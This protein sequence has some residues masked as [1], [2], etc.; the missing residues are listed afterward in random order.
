MR[1]TAVS[2]AHTPVRDALGR[3]LGDPTVE[4]VYWLPERG[5]WVHTDGTRAAVPEAAPGRS[6]TTVDFGDGRRAAIVHDAAHDQEAAFLE[7]ALAEALP[8]LRVEGLETSL[9]AQYLF[10]EKI[11]DTAPSLLINLDL[12]G[13]IL[14]QNRSAVQ[15]AG[16]TEEDELRGLSFVDVFTDGSDR[17]GDV[18]RFLSVDASGATTDLETVFS[19]RRGETRAIAWRAAP[20]DDDYGNVISIVV[21]GTDVSERKARE[22]ELA[23][24]R[25]ATATV[26]QTIPSV[27]VVLGSDLRIV[28]RDVNNPRAGVNDAFRAALGWRD[29]D[30]VSKDFLELIAV[31][32][33][34]RAARVLG[35]AAE[36][37]V[38]ERV[39]S[40]WLGVDGREP[41]FEWN[42][43]PMVDTTGRNEGLILISGI[44]VTD[45]RRYLAEIRASRA[46]IVESA[47]EARRRIERDLHDGAQQR[48]VSLSLSLRLARAKLAG[49]PDEV[50]A[51]LE[52]AISE[53]GD[54]LTE[55]R[56][57]ARGIHPVVLTE[58]GLAAA[59]ETLVARAQIEVRS[60]IAVPRLDPAVEAAVYFVIAEALTNVTKYAGAGSAVVEV[61]ADGE[62]VHVSI[63]DD[64]CGGA[65]VAGGS[66]LRGLSDRLGAL[67]G[68]LAVESPR[69]AGT[70]VRARIPLDP[71]FDPGAGS[72]TTS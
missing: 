69:G 15:A 11:T 64:G 19:N 46:R 13:C 62:A 6:V 34:R 67:D 68:T 14:N 20:L 51:I 7:S 35:V 53:L 47:D 42:A 63:A 36:G 28:D 39:E 43:A 5:I 9:R 40:R 44:D 72:A 4:V 48:L 37:M 41:V 30:L 65:D 18:A 59:V 55:L 54:A 61:T 66:G 45:R 71:A 21:A 49:H 3:A 8:D 16:L 1:T 70:T 38:S 23:R 2:A 58:R 27:I 32:D 12:D 52:T 60:N 24:E 17:N 33:R 50:E 25:D 10:L 31:A 57:L 29:V 56:E 22:L 26:L